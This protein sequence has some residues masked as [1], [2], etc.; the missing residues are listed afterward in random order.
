MGVLT[1]PSF[2]RDSSC[3]SRVYMRN[4]TP[5]VDFPALLRRSLTASERKRDSSCSSWVYM[6][7]KTLRGG[8]ASRS[9]TQSRPLLFRISF[10]QTGPTVLECQSGFIPCFNMGP[11]GW[12]AEPC[13]CSLQWATGHHLFSRA[14]T[15]D[16]LCDLTFASCFYLRYTLRSTFAFHQSPALWQVLGEESFP[17]PS[18]SSCCRCTISSLVGLAVI[19]RLCAHPAVSRRM[20]CRRIATR[21]MPS[22]ARPAFEGALAFADQALEGKTEH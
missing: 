12:A 7:N 21:R 22:Q 3:S 4:Q 8:G 1:W 11:E 18:F 5:R 20:W 16:I 2:K 13:R 9:C 17:L 15:C 19:R 14:F 10:V 6:R